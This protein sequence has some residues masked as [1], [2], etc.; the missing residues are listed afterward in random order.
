MPPPPVASGISW[1]SGA[2]GGSASRDGDV[3]VVSRAHRWWVSTS[4]VEG[5]RNCWRGTVETLAYVGSHLQ[6]LVQVGPC[7][8]KVWADIEQL[9]VTPGTEVWV[10]IEPSACLVMDDE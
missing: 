6:V 3:V 1:T 7:L 5:R 8:L 4:P 2:G 10:G 9:S